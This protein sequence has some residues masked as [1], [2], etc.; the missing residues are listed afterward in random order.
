MMGSQYA[1][2]LLRARLYQLPPSLDLV[3]KDSLDGPLP[4]PAPR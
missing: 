3:T 1:A 4:Q 2:R